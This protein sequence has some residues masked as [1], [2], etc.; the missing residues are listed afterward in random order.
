M[1]NVD[2]SP[3]EWRARR[4]RKARHAETEAQ[5]HARPELSRSGIGPDIRA[6]QSLVDEERSLRLPRPRDA[7]GKRRPRA[8]AG[9]Q[10]RGPLQSERSASRAE[11][12]CGIRVGGHRARPVVEVVTERPSCPRPAPLAIRPE[13]MA[14]SRVVN[15][16][17]ITIQL[18]SRAD[19]QAIAT[20]SRDLIEC[21]LGWEY[22]TE[23]I[24]ELIADRDAVS[25][26]ARDGDRVM[27]FAIMT[28]R[29]DY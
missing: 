29:D 28:F 26:V 25:L 1:P 23:R 24:R 27:G 15:S 5:W 7:G 21:G 6:V 14:Q 3:R 17:N 12:P 18:A 16:Q 22:R 10:E 4:A 20:M 19:A 11:L 8:C 9:G 2:P 13:T